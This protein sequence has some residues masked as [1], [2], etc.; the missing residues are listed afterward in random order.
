MDKEYLLSYL[1][2]H[3]VKNC[4]IINF[5]YDYPLLRYERIGNSIGILGESDK[6]WVYFYS[7]NEEE[8]RKLL[9]KFKDEKNFAVVNDWQFPIITEGKEAEWMLSCMKFYLPEKKKIHNTDLN[10]RELSTKMAE[11]I[12]KNYDYQKFTNIEYL[13]DRIEKNGGFGFFLANEM[14][15]WVMTHDDGAIGVLHVMENHRK[16]GYARILMNAIINKLR[17]ERKVPFLQIEENNESSL[18]LVKKLGFV[19]LERVHWIKL[20]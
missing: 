10:V 14:V 19:P 1:F 7:E 17:E 20:K 15:G 5:I 18:R 2:E 11:Y 9:K 8:F 13:E 6:K 3:P 4:N 12:Y 16:K